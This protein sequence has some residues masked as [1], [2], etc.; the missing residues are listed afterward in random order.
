M[1]FLEILNEADYSSAEKILE[2][3]KNNSLR[4]NGLSPKTILSKGDDYLL[5][6]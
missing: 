6:D 5:Y 3:I 1:R 4:I 2:Q